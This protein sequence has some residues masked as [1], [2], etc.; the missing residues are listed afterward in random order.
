MRNICLIKKSLIVFRCY[1]ICSLFAHLY[2]ILQSVNKCPTTEIA[3]HLLTRFEK[4]KLNCLYLEDQYYDLIRNFTV[5][6][7]NIRD[8]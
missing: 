2:V 1:N 5:E 8:R 4:L 7:E 3:L 6:I